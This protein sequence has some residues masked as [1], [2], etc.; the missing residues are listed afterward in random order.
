VVDVAYINIWGKRGGAV[1][2]DNARQYAT[3]EFAESFIR[4]GIDL[5]PIIMPLSELLRGTKIYSF[6]NLS[7]QTFKG[8][9]G[10][11][12]DSLPDRYGNR[13]INE[14]LAIRGKS[15]EDF[16]IVDRLCYIGK[17][18]M[19]ALEFEP[20]I[21][22]AMNDSVIIEIEELVSLAK[23]VLN[24]RKEMN[25]KLSRNYKEAVQE[26]I[27]VGTSAGG[28]RA[29]AVIALNENTGEIRSGQV[30]APEGFT[31]WILKFDG[32]SD[33][34]LGQTTGFG[35]IEYAY[36]KMAADA[37]INMEE[38]RLL[39]ESGRAHF[40]TRRFD[41]LKGNKKIHMQT[42]CAVAHFDYNDPVSYSYEQLFQVMRKM[43]L[44]YTDFD[45][46]FRRMVFNAAAC[47][48]D[49]HTKNVSFLLTQN[50][51]WRLSPAYD[52][53]YSHNPSGIWTKRHQMSVN[54]KREN[55]EYKDLVSA[56]KENNIK[57]A[58]DIISE[59]IGAIS[60]WKKYG[61][62]AGVSE[63]RIKEIKKNLKIK[64][65]LKKSG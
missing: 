6:P 3:I 24:Q 63:E 55:I 37:G 58:A 31:H 23:K 38:C 21:R 18:G 42:L 44:P 32:V 50:D 36:Y 61:A 26:I 45:Q 8:L 33:E 25:L 30:D 1:A 29:K 22:G 40:M 60:N 15:I 17:R 49:D 39:E 62:S 46:M 7:K 10:I 19:G 43:K 35:R 64:D 12:A 48:Y 56:G 65:F 16:N 5:A 14:W 2:W 9:P 34:V 13:L 54:G 11:L 20:A 28:A 4:E 59:V 53:I 52:V 41:R 27:R 47:N 51:Q 57:S